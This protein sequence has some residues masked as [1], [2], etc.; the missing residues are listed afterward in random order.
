METVACIFLGSNAIAKADSQGSA[1]SAK[2][3][4]CTGI[5]WIKVAKI[6]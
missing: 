2:K 6:K 4:V 5:K 1:S 3:I